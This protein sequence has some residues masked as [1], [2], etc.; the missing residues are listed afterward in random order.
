MNKL[1]DMPINFKPSPSTLYYGFKYY[2]GKVALPHCLH[3]TWR[4]L[5]ILYAN[6]VVRYNLNL[7][8]RDLNP[9]RLF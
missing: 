6:N 2:E 4:F 1:S 3:I 5:G 8:A 7:T 9:N